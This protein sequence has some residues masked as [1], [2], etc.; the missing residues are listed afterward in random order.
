[1]L[2]TENE[3]LCPNK[4]IHDCQVLKM[5]VLIMIT[6][7]TACPEA[8]HYAE[9]KR[10]VCPSGGSADNIWTFNKENTG[11]AAGLQDAVPAVDIYAVNSVTAFLNRFFILWEIKY[12]KL[13]KYLTR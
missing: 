5:C 10:K 7:M 11:P 9:K 8:E 1:M 4:A 3:F 2:S 12:S 6:T 13:P